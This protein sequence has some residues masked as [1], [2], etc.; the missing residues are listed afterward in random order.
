ML[1]QCMKNQFNYLCG[2]TICKFVFASAVSVTTG[3]TQCISRFPAE[4]CQA[5]YEDYQTHCVYTFDFPTFSRWLPPQHLHYGPSS[6]GICYSMFAD[7]GLHRW[8]YIGYSVDQRLIYLSNGLR[9]TFRTN[10]SSVAF[11]LQLETYIPICCGYGCSSLQL[12]CDTRN[13]C[14]KSNA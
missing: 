10:F 12:K 1:L 5:K 9:I 6:G 14:Q 3:S 4:P 13:N 11:E 7:V 2:D 8:V